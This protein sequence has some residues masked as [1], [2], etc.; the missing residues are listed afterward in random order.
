MDEA[1]TLHKQEQ[2][3]T[4][5]TEYLLA[6]QAEN[7]VPTTSRYKFQAAMGERQAKSGRKFQ[8]YKKVNII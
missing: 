5:L 8:A 6:Q 3:S 2:N 7:T 1:E 4:Q